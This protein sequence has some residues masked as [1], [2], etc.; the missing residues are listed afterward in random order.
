MFREDNRG[1]EAG[2]DDRD[3]ASRDNDV[4]T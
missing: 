4:H 2:Y 3:H 1:Y